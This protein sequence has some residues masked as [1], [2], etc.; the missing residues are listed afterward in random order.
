[1]VKLRVE[2][3]ELSS[4][5]LSAVMNPAIERIFR[6]LLCAEVSGSGI[7]LVEEI[8]AFLELM[9]LEERRICFHSDQE[10]AQIL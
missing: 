8:Q 5:R 7:Q 1:M 6:T 9:W 3:F 10:V 2:S 4:D